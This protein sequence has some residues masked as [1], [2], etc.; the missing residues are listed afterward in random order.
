MKKDE[1]IICKMCNN[2]SV[3][4]KLGLL[5]IK[6]VSYSLG[7]YPKATIDCKGKE[8]KRSPRQDG[9]NDAVMKLAKLIARIDK[10]MVSDDFIFLLSS[11]A[12]WI[13]KGTF[14]LNMNY[15]FYYGADCEPVNKKD[16]PEV[17]RL[18]QTYGYSGLSYWVAKKRG[19]PEVSKKDYLS[20]IVEV[21]QKES[22]RSS[23]TAERIK[24]K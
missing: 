14:M 7:I 2:K 19:F 10:T 1:S 9:W 21:K 13:H 4:K 20:G 11:G 12:G 24:V 22:I 16:I 15:T 5:F 3:G 6:E 17:V 18:F 23:V 8:T